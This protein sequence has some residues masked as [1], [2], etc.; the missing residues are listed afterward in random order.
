ML[1][2]TGL[3]LGV[4]RKERSDGTEANHPTDTCQP[5]RRALEQQGWRGLGLEGSAAHR[6]SYTLLWNDQVLVC[7]LLLIPGERSI[8]HSHESGELSITFSDPL[9]PVASYTPGGLFH[10][11]YVEPG[12]LERRRGSCR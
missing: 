6:K 12:P 3:E 4:S 2:C 1:S 10:G 11:M 8:R 7:A 5:L 9:H